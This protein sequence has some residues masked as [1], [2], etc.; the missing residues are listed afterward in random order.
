MEDNSSCVY[1][2]FGFDCEGNCL[3]DPNTAQDLINQTYWSVY[4]VDCETG[5]QVFS[6]EIISFNDSGFI[7]FYFS[8]DQ[9][10]LIV[11]PD[12]G[13][14]IPWIVEGN[15]VV[16]IY[17]IP[18][19]STDGALYAEFDEGCILFVPEEE[20][21]A[22]EFA[23]NYNPEI[24]INNW[25]LCDYSCS[26]CMDVN[27]CNYNP[28]ATIEDYCEYTFD[29]EL[30]EFLEPI[31]L[32]VNEGTNM[33]GVDPVGMVFIYE[34]DT[35][36]LVTSFTFSLIEEDVNFYTCLADGCY[37][38][39]LDYP[40]EYEGL[41]FDMDYG[42]DTDEDLDGYLN[43]QRYYFTFGETD[44]LG[45][46]FDTEADNYN[47]SAT[48]DNGLC[49]YNDNC[50]SAIELVLN[51]EPITGTNLGATG[52]WAEDQCLDVDGD[53]E[54]FVNSVWYS[55]TVP[56]G[57]FV[58]RTILDGTMGD[59]SMDIYMSCDL[60]SIV[61]CN[62][63]DDDLESAIYF[64]CGELT[65]G[66]TILVRV[67][68][69][70]NSTGSFSIVADS[71]ETPG[72]IYS[73][74]DNYDPCATIDDGSCIVMGCTDQAACNFNVLA[75]TMG[76]CDYESCL[77]CMD[78]SACNY[79]EN[80]SIFDPSLCNYTFVFESGNEFI[81][82][83]QMG[84][85]AV[86]FGVIFTIEDDFVTEFPI[87]LESVTLEGLCLEPGCY[88]I[89]F[90]FTS[91]FENNA[92]TITLD[93]EDEISGD[94]SN[95]D[96]VYF[97]FGGETCPLGC[98][99]EEA[100]NYDFFA[101]ADDGT[102]LYNDFCISAEELFIDG[103]AVSGDNSN[104]GG[105]LNAADCFDDDDVVNSVWFQMEVPEGAFLIR[106]VLEGSMD[107]SMIE[108]YE[109]CSD[110]ESIA[111][112]DDEDD[113]ESQVEFDCGELV[114]GEWIYIRVDGYDESTGS[115]FILAESIEDENEGC[116]DETAANYNACA[117]I[118]D[119][120]C[121]FEGCTDETAA[122][123]DEDATI[124]DGSCDYNC[125]EPTV[126]YDLMGCND[127]DDTFSVELDVTNTMFSGPFIIS[128]NLNDEEITVTEDGVYSYGEFGEDDDVVII[129]TSM[130]TPN[131]FV[132]SGI[133]ACP[134]GIAEV[135]ANDWMIFPNPSNAEFTLQMGSI[136]ANSVEVFDL[137]GR[138]IFNQTLSAG[139]NKLIIQS[140][141]WATGIYQVRLLSDD[142]M[143][144]KRLVVNH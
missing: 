124:D 68:G 119:G 109:S 9:G 10:E 39:T 142:T 105:S 16:G 89:G 33:L 118:D 13:T 44:C 1:A 121:E 137:A 135:D 122:N 15:C 46:C 63:D 67:D 133:L 116:T 49:V 111:C 21:C 91:G 126:L 76:E 81:P 136:D 25:D 23:C 107:D 130:D 47:P 65:P 55:L 52:T 58:V 101:T 129:L 60:E 74:A 85:Q 83:G 19:L 128:N 103:E 139:T 45:G 108:V 56:E 14:E 112:N 125:F 32:V 131:C 50:E 7:D 34:A 31:A 138:L 115:F 75:N 18:A 61:D 2:E 87:Y 90:D 71:I 141:Q 38:M 54:S 27:A 40:E 77:G 132:S 94:F 53:D 98:T 140:D 62:D 80:A 86:G 12:P 4:F 78:S 92:W 102:C 110:T 93:G 5:D 59:S 17:Y 95:F 8:G 42:Q 120:S 48:F 82:L 6:E 41:E 24:V 36:E 117:N 30:V 26:G 57:A 28:E 29:F 113:L 96:V 100:D 22:D 134:L 97:S 88:Y 51:G 114:P 3:G 20:G 72:C 66:S 69:Y 35:D 99:D 11:N 143:S 104:A 79:D 43:N 73:M 127:E 123:Y 64:D 37:Y 106:T 84:D 70:D 144:M